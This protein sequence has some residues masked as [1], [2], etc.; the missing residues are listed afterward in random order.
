[1]KIF[2]VIPAFN[3]EKRIGKVLS[4][5]KDQ[6]FPFIVI[7]DGSKDKTSQIAKRYT[8]YVLRHSINLGKG[9]AL[10]TGCLAA[11]KLGAEA[12]ILMDSDGQHKASDLPKFV[13][14]LKICDVVFGVRNFGKIPLVRLLGNKLITTIVSILYGINAQDI[15]CG[16]KAF[17]R[18]SFEKIRWYS[19]GYSVETEIV[20]LTG[21]HHL[22]NCEV[23]VATLYYDKFKG[24][25]IE[26]GFG[27]IFEI[28]QFKLR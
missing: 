6:K 26:Q 24:L 1:M 11:F 23:P 18:R 15:L 10:K 20:A 5:V 13:K 22:K 28:I 19:S 2:I 4:D 8:P 25:S 17:T 21:K 12:V 3:E 14:A 27:I 9:A 16:F 7:D